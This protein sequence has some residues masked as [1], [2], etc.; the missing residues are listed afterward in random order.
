MKL[1]FVFQLFYGNWE[2][3]I[4]VKNVIFFFFEVWFV[5]FIFNECLE[6][7]C[8]FEVEVYLLIKGS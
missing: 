8:L 4:V 6:D 1:C 2:G 3:V 7:D 5:R